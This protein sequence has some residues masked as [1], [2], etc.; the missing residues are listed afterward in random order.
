MKQ[1][2]LVSMLLWFVFIGINFSSLPFWKYAQ[3]ESA[4]K[5]LMQIHELEVKN[6]SVLINNGIFYLQNYLSAE[7]AKSLPTMEA[8]KALSILGR[9]NFWAEKLSRDLQIPYSD[10]EFQIYM[11][12]IQEELKAF[13]TYLGS[14]ASPGSYKLYLYGSLAKGRFGGNS[15]VDLYLATSNKG[16]IGKIENG[17]YSKNHPDFRG[18]VDIL[19][20][21]FSDKYL[22]APM[23]RVDSSQLNSID[24]T[25]AGIL[26]EMGFHFRGKGSA[27]K[28]VRRR[29]A[30]RYHLEFNPIEDRVYFLVKKSQRLVKELRAR[31]QSKDAQSAHK[32]KAK[33]LLEDFREVEEDLNLILNDV[34][35]AR[36][37]RIKEVISAE[38]YARLENHRSER[39]AA[40]IKK[41]SSRVSSSTAGK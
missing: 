35:N 15:S 1:R 41:W 8:E 39:L 38:S 16:L 10:S 21:S 12:Q 36:H 26:S 19:T 4:M 33:D 13:L 7:E 27:K 5:R 25:Y 9:K 3:Y 11:A 17:K 18:N 37:Q 22:L 29:G 32:R 23:V 28:L 2:N 6:H 34:Q 40:T 14:V 24:A 30:A 31:K 20:S